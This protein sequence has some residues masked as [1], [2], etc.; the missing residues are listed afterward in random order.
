MESLG[1]VLKSVSPGVSIVLLEDSNAH[2][3][4]NGVTRRGMIERN[5][6]S[7]LNPSG[8]LFL[9]I[10]VSHGLSIT[11]NMLEHK[12]AHKCIWYQTTL[13]QRLMIDFVVKSLDLR[14]YVLDTRMKR[15]AE[16]SSD[17]LGQTAG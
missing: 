5:S 17:Q 2:V 8:V 7:E 14:P 11:N 3:G 15:G 9:D 1:G 6:L 13:G 12:V 16:L 10:C 4:N